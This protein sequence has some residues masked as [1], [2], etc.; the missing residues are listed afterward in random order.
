MNFDVACDDFFVNINL[1]TTMTLPTGRETVLHFC[2]AA[3]KQF[4]GMTN[5]FR[6]DSGDQVLESDRDEGQYQWLEL[7]SNGLLSGHFNPSDIEAAR[8]FHAWMLQRSIYHLGISGLDIECLDVLFGFNLDYDGNRDEIVA[9]ALLESSPLTSLLHEQAPSRMLE[10]EPS[11][12][13][14]LN[15]DCT[16]QARV[17]VETRCDSYQ[18]RTGR[19]DHEPISVYLTIRQSPRPGELPD[20]L[21]WF[22]KQCDLC[23][24]IANRIIIPQV[25]QPI[26]TAIATAR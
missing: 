10:C 11:F 15:E 4:P 20:Q 25:V 12:V 2:E 23:E 14:S 16:M 18:V 9:Q 7:Q 13:F 5:F 6:R 1:H 22:S 26:A 17:A 8:K 19:Y 24:D 3:Q 21:E